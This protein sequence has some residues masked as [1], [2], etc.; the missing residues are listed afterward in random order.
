MKIHKG[1]ADPLYIIL[2]KAVKNDF[3]SHW[4]ILFSL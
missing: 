2:Y 3:N 4:I 1:N